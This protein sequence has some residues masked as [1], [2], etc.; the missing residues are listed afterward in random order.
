MPWRR[1]K[2][3]HTGKLFNKIWV[4]LAHVLRIPAEYADSS[5]FQFMHLYQGMS[6]NCGYKG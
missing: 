4:F 5:V 2:Y 3:K 1:N 6:D